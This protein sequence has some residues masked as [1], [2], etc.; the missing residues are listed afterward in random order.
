MTKTRS[1]I[2]SLLVLTSTLTAEAFQESQLA[3]PQT[4]PGVTELLGPELADLNGDGKLD[5]LLG[6]Y[7]GTLFF[8]ENAGTPKNP[9]FLP[10]KALRT[11][12]GEIR[13]KHW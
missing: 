5:L 10:P 11:E 3:E 1:A 12:K 4:L 8:R 6:N 9:K 13:L 7:R 2:V